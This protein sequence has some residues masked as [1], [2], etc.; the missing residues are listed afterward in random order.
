L[1]VS[2]RSKRT[3]VVKNLVIDRDLLH[4]DH[5]DLRVW[6]RLLS[7]TTKIENQL[8]ARLRDF[9]A[10]LPRFDLMAQLERNPKGLRMTALSERLMVSCG[11]VTG[12]T[13]QLER[14]GFVVRTPDPVDRRVIIVSLTPAGLKRFRVLAKAHEQWIIELFG[15]VSDEDKRRLFTLLQ[16]LRESLNPDSNTYSAG[17]A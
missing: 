10:T 17:T 3:A 7:C 4:E 15:G 8:R 13:D 2:D 6:L 5:R 16:R 1:K 9:D 14:A 11:N 12:V